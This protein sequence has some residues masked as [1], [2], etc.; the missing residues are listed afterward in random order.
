MQNLVT[1]LVAVGLDG[2]EVGRLSTTIPKKGGAIG[3]KKKE[4]C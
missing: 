2:R 3:Q 1:R 4:H